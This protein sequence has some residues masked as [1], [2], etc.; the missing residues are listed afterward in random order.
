MVLKS[1]SFLAILSGILLLSEVQ[2]RTGCGFSQG[3]EN[4][5]L[6]Y[7]LQ[8]CFKDIKTIA[9]EKACMFF[10]GRGFPLPKQIQIGVEMTFFPPS[11]AGYDSLS[12]CLRRGG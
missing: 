12:L 4:R 3:N 10:R 6:F 2:A 1:A 11:A 5:V 7:S 9:V 8:G